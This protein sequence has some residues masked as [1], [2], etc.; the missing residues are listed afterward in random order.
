MVRRLLHEVRRPGSDA[1]VS[2]EV[3]GA[4]VRNAAARANR[5]REAYRALALWVPQR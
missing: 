2:H 5:E 1:S 4:L 3:H